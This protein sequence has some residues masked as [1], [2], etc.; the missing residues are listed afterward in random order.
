MFVC[1]N[2][3]IRRRTWAGMFPSSLLKEISRQKVG[4][5]DD[6]YIAMEGSSVLSENGCHEVQCQI[7]LYVIVYFS[8][9]QHAI[10]NAAIF[11]F[12]LVQYMIGMN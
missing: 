5:R 2:S 10:S 1:K 4:L 11:L 3:T 9:T 7:T 8:C 6:S 12:G